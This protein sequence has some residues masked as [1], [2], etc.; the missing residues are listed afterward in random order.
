MKNS[1]LKFT[2]VVAAVVCFV[3]VAQAIPVSGNIGF[4]GGAQLDTGDVNSASEVLGWVTPTVLSGASGSF[5]GIVGGTPVAIASPWTFNSAAL[6]PFW[7]VGGFTFNLLS[8]TIALPSS[9]GF[10]NVLLTGS[11]S[12]TGFDTTPFTG[13]FQIANPSS[14]GPDQFTARLSFAS[15]PDGGTTVMLLGSALMGLGLLKR[16]FMA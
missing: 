11:V 13:S 12:A 14:G 16:K 15:V 9:P 7:S 1:W 10:L 3:G 4:S 6:A 2:A 5:S 8:S